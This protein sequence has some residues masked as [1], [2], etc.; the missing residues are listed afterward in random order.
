MGTKRH[1]RCP[2]GHQGLP[3]HHATGKLRPLQLACLY[4]CLASSVQMVRAST[5]AYGRSGRTSPGQPRAI[6][7]R[8]GC[9]RRCIERLARHGSAPWG[10]SQDRMPR[11]HRM[12]S[13]D[14]ARPALQGVH[15]PGTPGRPRM[16]SPHH[17]VPCVGRSA[18]RVLGLL[19]GSCPPMPCL[20]GGFRA[21]IWAQR[22]QHRV[23]DHPRAR[24]PWFPLTSPSGASAPECGR[25]PPPDAVGCGCGAPAA[26]PPGGRRAPA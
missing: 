24:A 6:S 1:G 22:R 23:P 25:S 9:Q 21:A 16:R 3:P 5:T 20:K 11:G 7:S 8:Q 4:T 18:P 14:G 19:L 15:L 17:F 13:I 26:P 10:Q 12:I 2:P